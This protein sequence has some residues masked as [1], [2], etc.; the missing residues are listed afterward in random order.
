MYDVLLISNPNVGKTTLF[1]SLTRSNE[2]TGNFHGVTVDKKC[3]HVKFQGKDYAFYDLPGLYSL[4]TFTEEENVAK[5]AILKSQGTNIVVVDSNSIKRNLY[6]C[7]QLKELGINFSVLINNNKYFEKRGNSIDINALQHALNMRMQ[8][9]DAKKVKLNKSLLADVEQGPANLSYLQ[10]ILT[11]LK[12]KTKL[13]MQQVLRGLN[14]CTE[15]LTEQEIDTLSVYAEKAVQ[16]R[17]N[18]LENALEDAVKIKS[19]YAYG[20]SKLDK[21]LLNPI[22]MFLGFN[23]IFLFSIYVIFFLVGPVVSEALTNIFNFLIV[24]PSMNLLC[25]ITDNLW[26]LQFFESGV[27]ASCTCIFTFLPQICLMFMFLTLLEDSGIIARM[28]YVFD[29]FLC[30]LGL[31]GKAIYIML[32]GFGCNTMSTMTTR[33]MNGK[34]LKAKTAIINPFFSCMARLPVYVLVATAFFG[35]F[36]YFVVAGL[37][38]VGVAVALFV[39]F[40]LNKTFLKTED[41]FLLLEFPPLKH[42]DFMHLLKVAKT[43]AADFI[44]RIFQVIVCVGIIVWVLTHTTFALQFTQEIK[45]SILFLILDKFTWIFAPIGLNST[46]IM[47]ALFVGIMAKELI[48]STMSI[49]NGVAENGALIASLTSATSAICFSPASAVSFLIFS[50]LYCPCVSNLEVIKKECGRGIMWL[51]VLFGFVVAYMLSFVCYV[52]ISKGFW[53]AT[54]VA[55]ATALITFSIFYVIKKVKQHKCLT[56]GRCR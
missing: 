55:V 6:L 24:N 28:C 38:L 53:F 39:A 18:F 13:S 37:Y 45:Q 22:V 41:A 33:N 49:C 46:G 31:N 10:E 15:G 54:I 52:A 21:F 12:A 47:C 40:L 8:F 29:D 23:A 11:E 9:V 5:R 48:V 20:E 56:C 42:V 51:A 4:N 27:F 19:Q 16:A 36:T 17:Y 35:K 44:K 2:H 34:N 25:M 50:L 1:N 43:N 14:G 7:L 30:K 3:K 26:L 32:L